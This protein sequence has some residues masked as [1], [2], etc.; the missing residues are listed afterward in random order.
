MEFEPSAI[1]LIPETCEDGVSASRNAKK[2]PTCAR[3]AANHLNVAEEGPL[4][5][6]SACASEGFH[7][8]VLL[9]GHADDHPDLEQLIIAISDCLDADNKNPKPFLWTVKANDI[10]E[11]VTRAQAT[12]NKRR[13]A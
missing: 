10:L 6:L 4:K 8:A 2:R 12:L 13:S 3:R 1:C 9:P 5:T 11:K 7:M